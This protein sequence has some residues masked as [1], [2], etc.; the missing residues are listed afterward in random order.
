MRKLLILLLV[1]IS[2]TSSVYADFDDGW[3]AYEKG[4]YKTAFI[5]WE[6]AAKRGDIDAQ[7]NLGLMY[8]NGKGALQ[9]DKQAVYWYWKA[10]E[11]GNV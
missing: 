10:A 3:D 7:Y 5:E 9:D 4:D 2:S 1:S 6:A 11:Q 8:N